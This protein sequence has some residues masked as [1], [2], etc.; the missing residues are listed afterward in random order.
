MTPLNHLEL[1]KFFTEDAAKIKDR[2]W[3]SASWMYTLMGALLAY[4]SKNIGN[5]A[6]GILK[7]DNHITVTVASLLGVVLSIYTAFMIKQYGDHIRGMW[8]RAAE[9]RRKIEGLSEVWFLRDAA[10]VAQDLAPNQPIDTSMPAVAKRLMWLCY[11]FTVVFVS[12]L[13]LIVF[14]D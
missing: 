14:L 4:I 2:M 1:W 9:V 6:S 5:D 3:V 12:L 10:K 11:G 13:G 8:N 7:I